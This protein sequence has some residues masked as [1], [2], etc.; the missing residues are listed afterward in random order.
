MG[1]LSLQT[2]K[3]RVTWIAFLVA[4]A[5]VYLYSAQQLE[6]SFI[7]LVQK[8][9]R[10]LNL[11][12][13]MW[14]PRFEIL[15][16]LWK[17]L[18][19]TL[20]MAVLG[21]ALGALL[22][23]PMVMLTSRTVTR[24]TGIYYPARFVM[25]LFR[26]IPAELYAILF[27]AAL[28]I[29]PL[30]G[31]PALTIFSAAIITKLTSE[32]AE[33]IDTGPIEALEATGAQRPAVV[34]YSVLPQIMPLFLSYSLY[35]FELNIRIA[36]ILAVVGAG[37]IGQNLV[38]ALDWFDYPAALTILMVIFVCVFGIDMISSRFRE[39]F[40]E[41]KDLGPVFTWGFGIAAGAAILWALSGV[42]LDVERI[43]DGMRYLGGMFTQ[44]FRPA[45]GEIGT[46]VAKMAESIQIA[47]LG[48]TI[49]MVLAFPFGFLCAR[50]LM[51]RTLAYGVRQG[52]NI[53][54]TFSEIILA[55]FLIAAF[56]PGPFAGVLTIGIHSIGMLSRLNYEVVETI[57]RGPLEALSSIGA[58]GAVRF[59]YAVLPQILPEFLAMA[60]YRFEINVRAATV[61]GIVGAG[62][63]GSVILR[64]VRQGR[65]PEVGLY[66][67]VVI[68]TV[69]IIDYL[70]AVIRRKIIEG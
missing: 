17:P 8:S 55:I 14:P 23:L 44:M 57:D 51:P 32:S 50:N 45:W 27:V 41:G 42:D 68:V 61:L 24:T 10:F 67:L 11:L 58:A 40:V 48:T 12:S 52:P 25:S 38:T 65:W 19:E 6:F 69:M 13:R 60:I 46:A 7:E 28:G 35:M 22:A 26:S 49:A 66:L 39:S 4:L 20:Q 56:G 47:L 5:W 18:F 34:V 62:G 70:S 43:T 31:I 16:Q 59:R 2:L 30:P 33:N 9:P 37:G 36:S 1:S 15:S 53:I 54:R 29:G 64:A 63:I 21:T 3:R